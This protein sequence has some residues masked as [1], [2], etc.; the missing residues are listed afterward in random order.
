MRTKPHKKPERK[1]APIGA[2]S[3]ATVIGE[4]P[5]VVLPRAHLSKMPDRWQKDMAA[6]LI[7][8]QFSLLPKLPYSSLVIQLRD[9]KGKLMK[10]PA[11]L[12]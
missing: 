8:Y 7:E 4:D 5:F 6:L 3:L 9:A 2:V 1:D 11:E 12:A 10:L